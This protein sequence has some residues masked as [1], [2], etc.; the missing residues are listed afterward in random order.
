MVRSRASLGLLA[1]A[2]GFAPGE[3]ALAQRAGFDCSRAATPIE[4][5]ICGNAE[6]AAA[7]RAMMVDYASLTAKLDPQGRAHLEADQARWLR[8]RERACAGEAEDAEECLAA[9]YR[10]RAGRL[11]LLADGAYPFVSEHAIVRA[12]VARGIPYSV[13]ASYPQFDGTSADF[14]AVNRQLAAAASQAAE[15]AVPRAGADAGEAQAGLAWRYDQ[16]FS[17]YRPSDRA[18]SAVVVF[19]SDDG[20]AEA[21]VGQTSLLVDLRTG[22]VAGPRDVFLAGDGWLRELA[23]RARP[24]IKAANLVELLQDP[25]RYAF[26]DDRLELSFGQDEG[27]PFTL[28]VSYDVLKPF[29]R[30]DGPIPP[31]I[32]P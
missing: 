28:E 23:R 3:G 14:D 4:R 17:L 26:L 19:E 32:P 29:L 7:D 20:G 10:D 21:V 1:V 24:G 9:R 18:I 16:A 22:R 5:A 31:P 8:N 25:R 30:P 11:K 2:A 12:G 6:L 13:D 27:G 15:R